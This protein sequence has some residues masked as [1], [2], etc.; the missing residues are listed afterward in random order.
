MTDPITE[1]EIPVF[2]IE[3]LVCQ[4][5]LRGAGGECHVPGCSFW[6]HD[7]PTGATLWWLREQRDQTV[8][9]DPT[10]GVDW[11]AHRPGGDSG[12]T[13]TVGGSETGGNR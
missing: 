3:T 8:L 10:A 12:D 5:C 4:L 9:C 2:R 1:P 6:L 7:A 11:R 13:V